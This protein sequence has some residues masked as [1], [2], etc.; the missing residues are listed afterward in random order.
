MVSFSDWFKKQEEMYWRVL[1]GLYQ[2]PNITFSF[3]DNSNKLVSVS[4]YV[5]PVE[6]RGD[7]IYGLF[8][9]E[10]GIKGFPVGF[11]QNSDL[12][13]TDYYKL[14]NKGLEYLVV[15]DGRRLFL[16]LELTEYITP[17]TE[18]EVRM[19]GL[20]GINQSYPLALVRQSDK[21]LNFFFCAKNPEGEII[22]LNYRRD[23]YSKP[24]KNLMS[25]LKAD[26][27]QSSSKS[28][29]NKNSTALVLKKKSTLRP[30]VKKSKKTVED[31]LYEKGPGSDSV[32]DSVPEIN[33]KNPKSIEAY[34]DKY[35]IK[36][37]RA[38]KM[39]SI[40]G[41]NY[42]TFIENGGSKE[43]PKEVL[44]L[45]GSSGVGKTLLART[46]AEA[47]GIP[48][49]IMSMVGKSS[50]GYVDESPTT[51][52]ERINALAP[53]E[54]A[55]FGLLII[56]EIDK[57]AMNSNSFKNSDFGPKLQDT[58]MEWT[59]GNVVQISDPKNHN[60]RILFDTSNLLFLFLGAF[61]G[62]RPE[63]S[64]EGIIV[65][66]LRGGRTLGF[67]VNQEKKE[68][69]NPLLYVTPEDIQKYGY[70]PEFVGRMRA[71]VTLDRL[72]TDDLIK[73]IRTAEGSIFKKYVNLFRAEGY[74]IEVEENVFREIAG[75]CNKQSGAR[76]LDRLCFDL[77]ANLKYDSDLYAKKENIIITTQIVKDILDN[78]EK[79]KKP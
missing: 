68:L 23:E 19:Y 70:K 66:R 61:Q 29:R 3:V 10:G 30:S 39:I 63:E 1:S 21:G 77:F 60:N 14:T 35:V 17:V 62:F 42:K 27:N 47:L 67:G 31:R 73:I 8:G 33:W 69:E 25:I 65:D 36:Q 48:Y 79:E 51:G 41:S 11:K 74:G 34:L 22:P 54:K 5:L 45:I 24:I 76:A 7:F 64:L 59:E 18:A 4:P 49:A 46:L 56:D 53:K 6:D 72:D 71:I 78:V 26:K 28:D 50:A 43:M 38:K 2:I 12:L 9:S 55:P 57:I 58:L 15:P 40:I 37:E 16:P 13:N 20:K 32:P 75:R 44:T 52:L